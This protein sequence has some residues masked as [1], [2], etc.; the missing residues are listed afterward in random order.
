MSSNGGQSSL[1]VWGLRFSSHGFGAGVGPDKAPE[2]LGRRSKGGTRTTEGHSL[3][4]CSDN[5]RCTKNPSMGRRDAQGHG[6]GSGAKVEMR[7]REGAPP[8]LLRG[9]P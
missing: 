6:G 7:P 5:T 3:P 8:F 1:Y 4:G 9:P 2:D